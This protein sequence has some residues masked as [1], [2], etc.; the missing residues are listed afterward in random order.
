MR[1]LWL[2]FLW[3]GQKAS[4]RAAFHFALTYP[5]QHYIGA[6]AKAI[7]VGFGS[8]IIKN[9]LWMEGNLAHIDELVADATAEGDP[10][11]TRLHARTISLSED[12]GIFQD[13]AWFGIP[14]RAEALGFERRPYLF[15]KPL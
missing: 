4:R 6:W 9:N 2:A 12:A 10:H 8:M 15:S 7:F 14:A 13:R 3:T 1:R 11:G 5:S